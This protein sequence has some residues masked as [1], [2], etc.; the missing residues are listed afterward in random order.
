MDEAGRTSSDAMDT[1][2]QKTIQVLNHSYEAIRNIGGFFA[3]V[4]LVCLFCG[5]MASYLV[6]RGWRVRLYQ[7]LKMEDGFPEEQAH[8]RSIHHED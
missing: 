3:F 8:L 7:R 4:L 1:Q 2:T 5:V 6:I